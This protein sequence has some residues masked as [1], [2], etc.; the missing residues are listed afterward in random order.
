M[1]ELDHVLNSRLSKYL[2]SDVVDQLPELSA[3]QQAVQ[4]LNTL[5]TNIRSFLPLYV[6]EDESRLTVD[7][8]SLSPGTF[9][10]AD[11]S[12]FTA[13]SE[14]L[15]KKMG[16]EGTEILT[17]VF[18]NY[19][20]RML[21]IIS[22]SDGQLLKFAGD[23]LLTFFPQDLRRKEAEK[24]INAGLRM[25]QAMKEHFQPIRI[26]ERMLAKSDDETL[27]IDPKTK[28]M[29]FWF[30]EQGLELTMSIGICRGELFE[31]LVGN[32]AQRD[33]IIMGDLPGRAMSAEEVGERDEVIIDSALQSQH[34]HIFQTQPLSNGFHQV[35]GRLGGEDVGTF[36][37]SVP[38]G[39]RRGKSSFLLS[40]DK[41]IFQDLQDQLMRVENIARYVSS[42]IVNKLVVARDGRI[43]SENRLATVIFV[44]FTG[45]AELLETW[46]HDKLDIITVIL[47]RYYG[48]IQRIITTNGGVLTRS[49]PYKLGSKL[50]ITFGAPVAHPDDPDRAVATALEMNRKVESINQQVAHEF[51]EIAHLYPFIKQRMGITQGEVFAGEVGWKQRREYTVMGDDVNLAARLMN[52]AEY[53]QVL[54]SER[55]YERVKPYF[56][57]EVQPEFNAKGKSK[58]IRPYLAKV[59]KRRSVAGTSDTPFIGREVILMS[60]NM[61]LMQAA[62]RPKSVRAIG[63][64]GDL[65]VGKTRLA[66]QLTVAA[67]NSGFKIAWA[68]CRAQNSRKATWATLVSQLFELDSNDS[69]EAQSAVMKTCLDKLNLPELLDEFQD[70]I[71][72]LGDQPPVRVATKREKRSSSKLRI[73][74]FSKLEDKAPAAKEADVQARSQLKR[75]LQRSSNSELPIWSEL[76]LGTS[77]TEALVSFLKAYTQENKTLIV[78]DNLHKE[79]P[80]A[81]NIL[82]RIIKELSEARLMIVGTYEPVK[83]QELR[84]PLSKFAV[85][86]LTEH[87]TYL[88]A[89]AILNVA[90]VGLR[91]TKYVWDSSS[92]RALF[93]E[94]LMQTLIENDQLQE[95]EGRV[96]LKPGTNLEAVPDN[97]RGLVISRVD[98]LPNV[99]RAL[100]RT[101]AVLGES[102]SAES[103][104]F[105]SE[106]EDK[107]EVPTVIEEL[108][109]LNIFEKRSGDEYR[110]RHGITQQAV[111]E[112]LSRLQ[113][114]KLHRKVAE[115]YR[116]EMHLEQNLL[117]LV[118]H[119]LRGG[120]P[121]G[122]V[123]ELDI[124]AERAQAKGDRDQALELYAKALEIFPEDRDLL[125]KLEAVHNLPAS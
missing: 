60:L 12:G 109:T 18:N 26:D 22:A 95:D 120:D 47:S 3:I 29:M 85:P 48:T 2:T 70:L 32:L 66:K 62:N 110:F 107:D 96:E 5:H 33:H 21:E 13:L 49:D 25:Q 69:I 4:R 11:V 91:L 42:E 75:A 84:I 51:P 111:Y 108:V 87:E 113:R 64:H 125:T 94:S 10:F 101:A 9:M 30:R 123:R 72:N 27:R 114:Q 24:A 34:E 105:T 56:E 81:L 112:E 28:A 100:V 36:E 40:S 53:G 104:A 65:G 82:N 73:D 78:I 31:S 57:I 50:L 45:F 44:H 14:K 6:A 86:D 35:L 17:Q 124:A 46:G 16:P 1:Q 79:N 103:L 68:T 39:N 118:D 90:E 63:L 15:M 106:I 93:I 41:E 7:N 116:S 8:S 38:R 117:I 122:A 92:G 23:A 97:I 43:E 80:R 89:A 77:V 37:I 76:E 55:I 61:A 121:L 115:F 52:R 20:G 67:E 83:D 19:F 102:F 58:P 98:R 88:M 54:I 74:L 59:P 71:L 99:A 119:L